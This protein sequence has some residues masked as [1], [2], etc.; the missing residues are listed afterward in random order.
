MSEYESEDEASIGRLEAVDL[1]DDD[2]DD[3]FNLRF[4]VSVT[5][6]ETNEIYNEFNEAVTEIEGKN[7]R[8]DQ[9]QNSLPQLCSSY[10][11]L[12]S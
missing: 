3:S 7:M 5:E 12:C 2:S 4:S 10:V 8:G 9:G 6:I 1:S 11:T